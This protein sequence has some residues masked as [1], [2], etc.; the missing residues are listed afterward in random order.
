MSDNPFQTPTIAS[1][2]HYVG[3]EIPKALKVL[4]ITC[5][6]LGS[7]GLLSSLAGTATLFFQADVLEF[8]QTMGTPDQQAMQSRINE[9]QKDFV[10]L[11]LVLTFGSLLISIV[12]LAGGIAVLRKKKW[13]PKFFSATLAMA[14]LFVFVRTAVMSFIQWQISGEVYKIMTG[15]IQGTPNVGT[16]ESVIQMSMVVGL[17]VGVAWMVGLAG[18]YLWGWNFLKKDRCQAFF[19]T[20]E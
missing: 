1:S 17:L 19:A 6:V 20:F 4:C 10:I 15:S 7:F 12:L 9:I 16:M 8:Q 2:N 11:N 14:A 18:F 3:S 13:G 5:I